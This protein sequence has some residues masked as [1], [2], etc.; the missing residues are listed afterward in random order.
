MLNPFGAKTCNHGKK[1]DE[2]SDVQVADQYRD[3]VAFN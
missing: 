2:L 1:I 3:V